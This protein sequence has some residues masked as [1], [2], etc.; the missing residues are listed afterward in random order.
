MLQELQGRKITVFLTLSAVGNV[1]VK[2]TVI[3]MDDS[4]MQIK[5]K[6]AVELVNISAI[7]KIV[8]HDG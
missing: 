6:K 5:G 3:Q 2:G 4:W 8:L 7:K 1:S